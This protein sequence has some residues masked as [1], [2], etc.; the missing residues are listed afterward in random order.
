MFQGINVQCGRF[1]KSSQYHYT[2][3]LDRCIP[4]CESD[5]IFTKEEKQNAN[6]VTTNKLLK[7]KFNLNVT[8]Y[9]LFRNNYLG[10]QMKVNDNTHND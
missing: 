8:W 7:V 5:I 6:K 3:R 10:R 4:L 9:I 2:A 1:K